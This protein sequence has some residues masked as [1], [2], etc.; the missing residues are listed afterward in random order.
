MWRT[1]QYF[2]DFGSRI[3]VQTFT[4]NRCQSDSPFQIDI[5]S[6][7]FPRE[8]LTSNRWQIDE[9]VSIG[10]TFLQPVQISILD[11]KFLHQCRAKLYWKV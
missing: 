2:V 11:K 8:V 5:I 6:R 1:H 9:D 3:H 10:Y 4:S 7:N